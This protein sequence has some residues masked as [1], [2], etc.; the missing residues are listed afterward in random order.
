MRCSSRSLSLAL[1]VMSFLEGPQEPEMPPVPPGAC[2]QALVEQSSSQRW[3]NRA[4]APGF[5]SR[6]SPAWLDFERNIYTKGLKLREDF[7]TSY[8]SD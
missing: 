6:H 4:H 8:L 2:T 7:T 3:S 5:S 1:R